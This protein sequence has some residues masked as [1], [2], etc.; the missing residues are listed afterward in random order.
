MAFHSRQVRLFVVFLLAKGLAGLPVRVICAV[1]R[2]LH[3]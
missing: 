1:V 3:C 2:V